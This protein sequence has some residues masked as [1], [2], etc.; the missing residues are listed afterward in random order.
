MEIEPY[1]KSCEDFA[2][3]IIL[4][5][6]YMTSGHSYEEVYQYGLE[7]SVDQ[8]VR[9]IW[10]ETLAIAKAQRRSPL[11]ALDGREASV[12]SWLTMVFTAG[13]VGGVEIIWIRGGQAFLAAVKILRRH[14]SL[15]PDLRKRLIED[16]TKAGTEVGLSSEFSASASQ[17][18]IDSVAPE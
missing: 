3:V 2:R 12:A 14:P 18:F 11:D 6:E 10:Q 5:G 15:E 9:Q 16:L 4:M 8:H 1:L 17:Q 7:N 13:I